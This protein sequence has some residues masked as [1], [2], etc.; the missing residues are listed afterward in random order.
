MNYQVA[1]MTG[2]KFGRLTVV[3]FAESDNHR[4]AIWLCSCT[5]GNNSLV[6]GANLRVGY[7]KSCGCLKEEL[8]TGLTLQNGKPSR[9]YR[10]WSTMK[11]RCL[12]SNHP[13]HDCY[14]GR[15]IKIYAEW[16]EFKAFHDWAMSNGYQDN[17]TIDRINNDG[18]YGPDN[19]RWA[20][21]KEQARN[22]RDNRNIVYQGDTKTMTE[23]SEILGMNYNTLRS[24]IDVGWTVEKAF[25]KPTTK[26]AN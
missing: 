2:L 9:L 25:N 13:K 24:R 6:A 26:G 3:K 16:M 14:G 7:T 21:L 23:W 19:C 15:G 1:D 8:N 17:L 5:C 10:I 22:R 12:N 11:Q 4:R 18:H 20:T